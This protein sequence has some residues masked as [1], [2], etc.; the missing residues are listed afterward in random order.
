VKKS[1]ALK[2][3]RPEVARYVIPLERKR[4]YF[5]QWHH[6]EMLIQITHFHKTGIVFKPLSTVPGF[7]KVTQ[8]GKIRYPYIKA[9]QFRPA[10]IHEI[11]C[12]MGTGTRFMTDYYGDTKNF[13]KNHG[14][15]L[16]Q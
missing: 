4:A 5:I 15:E 7:N 2:T 3:L 1:D 12:S 16:P 13:L 11:T 6:K 8:S 10:T 9:H 14:L